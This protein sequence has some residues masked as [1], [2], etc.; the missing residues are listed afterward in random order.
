M[1]K[2]GPWTDEEDSLLRRT[3]ELLPPNAHNKYPWNQIAEHVPNRDPTRCRERWFNKLDPSINR[4]PW[5]AEEDAYILSYYERYGNKWAEITRGLRTNRSNDHVKYRA[6]HLIGIRKKEDPSF[7]ANATTISLAAKRKAPVQSADIRGFFAMKPPD[8]IQ[9]PTPVGPV[10]SADIRGFFSAAHNKRTKVEAAPGVGLRRVGRLTGDDTVV[11]EVHDITSDADS[12]NDDEGVSGKGKGDQDQDVSIE[13]N[14]NDKTGEAED[15]RTL[16]LAWREQEKLRRKG[17]WKPSGGWKPPSWT[18]KKTG[19]KEATESDNESEGGWSVGAAKLPPTLESVSID[20]LKKSTNVTS[21][22]DEN[23]SSEV[24]R[25]KFQANGVTT[26]AAALKQ[27]KK[28]TSSGETDIVATKKTINK[29]E[30]KREKKVIKQTP[31]SSNKQVSASVVKVVDQ[32]IRLYMPYVD[33]TELVVDRGADRS[34]NDEEMPV[35]ENPTDLLSGDELSQQGE[36][37]PQEDPLSP[38]DVRQEMLNGASGLLDHLLLQSDHDDTLPFSDFGTLDFLPLDSVEE[39]DTSRDGESTANVR[40]TNIEREDDQKPSPQSSS[41]TKT[42]ANTTTDTDAATS[43]AKAKPTKTAMSGRPPPSLDHVQSP[44]YVNPTDELL[45]RA[46]AA[47]HELL[48]EGDCENLDV[49]RMAVDY[50]LHWKPEPGK[51]RVI[52]LAESHGFTEKERVLRGPGLDPSILGDLYDGPRNY[53]NLVYSLPFG[54]PTALEGIN[55]SGR[56]LVPVGTS[57]AVDSASSTTVKTG[58]TEQKDG[59]SAVAA[60]MVLD[61][62]DDDDQSISTKS[63]GTSTMIDSAMSSAFNDNSAGTSQ[64]WTLLAACSRGTDRVVVTTKKQNVK[65]AFAA[66]VLKGGGLPVEDRLKAKLEILK[67]LKKRGIWLIDAS[68]L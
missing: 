29:K 25:E 59:S 28:M 1:V 6:N 64:F 11:V 62:A 33:H 19:K 60:I 21:S 68:M 61:G 53:I 67:N 8:G 66:D 43:K 18:P 32:L 49:V 35:A 22:K 46:H 45:I 54:E 65:S 44:S 14:D 57:V 52:L 17:V 2:V 56:V 4:E 15:E 27:S 10:K 38:T 63:L 31:V 20:I 40:S 13:T 39:A 23:K 3:I 16:A 26:R 30:K 36:K 12:T 50:Y 41:D 24:K 34:V 55:G 37:S 48:P 5:T 42:E 7:A 51:T 9:R 47:M 58:Q